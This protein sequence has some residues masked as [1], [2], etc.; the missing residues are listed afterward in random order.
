ME[1]DLRGLGF[2]E[3]KRNA[4]AEIKAPT[5]AEV[6]TTARS[7]ALF[8][9]ASKSIVKEILLYSAKSSLFPLIN[10]ENV[11]GNYQ[12]EGERVK[13]TRFRYRSLVYS[14]PRQKNSG[15]EDTKQNR[16]KISKTGIRPKTSNTLIVSIFLY[17]SVLNSRS[18]HR[19][20]QVK[21]KIENYS[22]LS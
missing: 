17:S 15:T 9:E 18:D 11:A 20:D 8:M 13:S 4:R 14:R 12:R 22:G 19:S 21:P 7:R 16:T 5:I 10:S 3:K 1:A 2:D 6:E